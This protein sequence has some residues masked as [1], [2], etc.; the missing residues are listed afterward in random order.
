MFLHDG[1]MPVGDPRVLEGMRLL[2]ERQWYAAHESFE[3]A[4]LEAEG[5][6][7]AFLQ[8]LIHVAV[9][10]EHLRRN[11]PR[12]ALSQ[13]RK[14]QPKLGRLGPRPCGIDVAAW[15]AEIGR[16]FVRIDLEGRAVA[17]GSGMPAEALPK[18]GAGRCRVR[19]GGRRRRARKA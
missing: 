3:A 4:W 8:S 12:G 17:Q 6:E 2:C 5:D 9:S 19:L 16:F 18:K 14:A 1:R 13:W 7:R 11:N 10:F 15:R